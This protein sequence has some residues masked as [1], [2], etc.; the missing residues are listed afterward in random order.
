[1]GPGHQAGPSGPGRQDSVSRAYL[2]VLST[3]QGV[4]DHRQVP[5]AGS[6]RRGFKNH[7]GAEADTSWPTHA[8][9]GKLPLRFL[10]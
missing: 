6:E 9:Q 7:A 8:F 4:R 10:S 1:M 5:R 2:S 3:H